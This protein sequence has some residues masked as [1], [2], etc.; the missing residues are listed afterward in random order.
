MAALLVPDLGGTDPPGRSMHALPL[1]RVR[2]RGRENKQTNIPLVAAAPG[3]GRGQSRNDA[4]V[5]GRTTCRPPATATATDGAIV[6]AC[7][8]DG[9]QASCA[10]VRAL[11]DMVMDGHAGVLA[12]LLL[13]V[14][15]GPGHRHSLCSS[16]LS[17]V[18][19]S[20]VAWIMDLPAGGATSFALVDA[21]RFRRSRF[22]SIDGELQLRRPSLS[23][24]ASY[25][26]AT[27]CVLVP[28]SSA[29]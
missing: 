9:T 7:G 21:L 25:V 20:G 28:L 11:M 18:R 16:L 22:R 3:A 27:S 15:A 17:F 1:R 5:G 14:S 8:R 10:G 6:H 19:C 24:H 13:R 26:L 4:R 29:T 23:N 12:L 2:E